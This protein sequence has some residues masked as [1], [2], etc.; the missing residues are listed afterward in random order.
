[1]EEIAENVKAVMR[2]L[3]AMESR[4]AKIESHATNK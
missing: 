4:L 3:E 2:G 1:M